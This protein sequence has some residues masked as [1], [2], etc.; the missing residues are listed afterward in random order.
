[1]I[2]CLEAQQKCKS[3]HEPLPYEEGQLLKFNCNVPEDHRASPFVW[4]IESLALYS[5][6]AGGHCAANN[7]SMMTCE[8]QNVTSQYQTEVRLQY[9]DIPAAEEGD[10]GYNYRCIFYVPDLG[11]YIHKICYIIS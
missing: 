3:V 11:M 6:S 8:V 5:K 7:G 1:M 9:I 10:C 4:D 2:S